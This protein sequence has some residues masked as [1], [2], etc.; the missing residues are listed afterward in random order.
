MAVCYVELNPVRAGIVQDAE[1]NI[2]PSAAA[3]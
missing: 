2:W 3:L 1:Y